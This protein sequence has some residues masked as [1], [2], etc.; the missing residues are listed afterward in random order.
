MDMLY[1]ASVTRERIQDH[2]KKE[3]TQTRGL[4][5]FA[6]RCVQGRRLLALAGAACAFVMPSC[7]GF[8]DSVNR[9]GD[10]LDKSCDEI[11]PD[12]SQAPQ[13]ERL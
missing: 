3:R 9:F 8:A 7:K 4:R 11:V 10:R 13:G 6:A 5:R 12:T 1:S 2:M